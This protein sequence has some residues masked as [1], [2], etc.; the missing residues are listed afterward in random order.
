MLER[1]TESAIKYSNETNIFVNPPH[2]SLKFVSDDVNR[3]KIYI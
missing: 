2:N 1:L 3:S